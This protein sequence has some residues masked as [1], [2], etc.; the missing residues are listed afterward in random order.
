MRSGASRCHFKMFLY[1]NIYSGFCKELSLIQIKISGSHYNAP[2]EAERQPEPDSAEVPVVG[3][4]DFLHLAQLQL[5]RRR[6][7]A[8]LVEAG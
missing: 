1:G 3:V 2:L 7:L 4:Q 8:N 5:D 6:L